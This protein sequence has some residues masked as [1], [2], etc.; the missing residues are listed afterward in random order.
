[1]T[2][3]NIKRVFRCSRSLKLLKQKDSS[4]Q[5]VSQS[6]SPRTNPTATDAIKIPTARGVTESSE[7]AEVAVTIVAVAPTIQTI[8]VA[9]HTEEEVKMFT[10][11]TTAMLLH[12]VS[13][14][15][16]CTR[17]DQ[18]T[19]TTV[20]VLQTTTTQEAIDSAV[21][22]EEGNREAGAMV[23]EDPAKAITVRAEIV[24]APVAETEEAIEEIATTITKIDSNGRKPRLMIMKTKTMM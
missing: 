6:R 20:A 19:T 3:I 24:A 1:M 18:Q 10:M 4:R 5:K 23:T 14:Q 8:V 21:N 7:D 11:Q 17:K 2:N 15:M 22:T 16:P 12:K 13:Q 9:D